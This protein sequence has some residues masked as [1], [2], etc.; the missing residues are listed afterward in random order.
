MGNRDL[1]AW[2]R[3]VTNPNVA[4]GNRLAFNGELAKLAAKSRTVPPT[5]Q[6]AFVVSDDSVDDMDETSSSDRDE[7]KPR[8]KPVAR[9]GK[10]QVKGKWSSKNPKSKID[11]EPE[12]IE[13]SG[14]TS[15]SESPPLNESDEEPTTSQG[16]HDSDA[17]PQNR[18]SKPTTTRSNRLSLPPS[19]EEQD[20]TTRSRDAPLTAQRR[21]S[22][23]S[24]S[25][26]NK[27]A[28]ATVSSATA[29]CEVRKQ[30]PPFIFNGSTAGKDYPQDEHVSANLLGLSMEFRVG[31][32]TPVFDIATSFS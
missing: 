18:P 20:K 16:E 19:R 32:K 4:P 24:A 8:T 6:K 31:I 3:H 22:G 27:T 5:I 29:D 1:R 10:K 28:G 26:Q 30:P 25:A 11:E 21:T 9:R 15:D 13:S 7:A 14:P 12:A 17:V 23:Q 2:F